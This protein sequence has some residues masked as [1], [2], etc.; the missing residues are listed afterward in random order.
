MGK[1]WRSRLTD[2]IQFLNNQQLLR[3]NDEERRVV[4]WI[5]FRG[6]EQISRQLS[7]GDS[8]R[9]RKNAADKE[10]RHACRAL[11]L[12]TLILQEVNGR[13]D[14]VGSYRGM[15]LNEMVRKIR[16][17]LVSI[18]TGIQRERGRRAQAEHAMRRQTAAVGN[19]VLP[20]RHLGTYEL[21]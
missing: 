17:R 4:A 16:Q 10:K 14:N 20:Q 19:G 2:T 8:A 13:A 3:D 11:I 1:N 18:R 7:I 6:A 21:R 12:V 15:S 5:S 9:S